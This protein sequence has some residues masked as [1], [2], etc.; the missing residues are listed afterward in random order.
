M[1]LQE[2]VRQGQKALQAALLSGNERMVKAIRAGLQEGDP[3]KTLKRLGIICEAD[4][5]REFGPKT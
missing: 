1:T 2:W 3:S 4:V 5:Q